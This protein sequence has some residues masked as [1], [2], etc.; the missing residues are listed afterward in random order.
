MGFKYQSLMDSKDIKVPCP[1]KDCREVEIEAYRWGHNPI[2]N[3]LN[4]LPNFLYNEK[5]N[6]PIRFNAE[7]DLLN[8]GLCSLSMFE[9]EKAAK[10]FWS[11]PAKHMQRVRSSLKYTHLLKGKITKEIGVSSVSKNLHFEL[12]EYEGVELRN[13]FEVVGELEQK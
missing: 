13:V 2:D 3:E 5:M 7:A 9:T 4:F 1:Y 8:C 11:S 6:I 12:F 10:E